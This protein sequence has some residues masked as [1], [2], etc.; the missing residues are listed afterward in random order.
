M[1][2]KKGTIRSAFGGSSLEKPEATQLPNSSITR[3]A[4][5]SDTLKA[6]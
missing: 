3:S 4:F 2:L 5:T 6:R 1:V